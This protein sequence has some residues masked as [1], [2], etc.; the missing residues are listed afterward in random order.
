MTSTVEGVPEIALTFSEEGFWPGPL[1]MIL[2]AKPGIY[3]PAFIRWA[4][5]SFIP[6]TNHPLTLEL[7][8]KVEI[9]LVGAECESFN[10][11][12]SNES[13]TCI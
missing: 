13:R 6:Y 7:I 8:T 12:K 5:N 2:K 4:P 1:T 3:A 10:K 9:P 11:A